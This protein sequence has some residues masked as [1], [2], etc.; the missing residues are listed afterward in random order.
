MDSF[1]P[2]QEDT[3]PPHSEPPVQMTT[4]APEI[5]APCEDC[6][7]CLASREFLH[8]DGRTFL[9]CE[10]CFESADHEPTY[11]MVCGCDCPRVGADETLCV[12]CNLR[13]EAPPAMEEDYDWGYVQEDDFPAEAPPPREDESQ[14]QWIEED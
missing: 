7:A 4:P 12:L 9:L 8:L 6:A 10:T 2:G 14:E 11:G 13:V 3:P 1:T 5:Q